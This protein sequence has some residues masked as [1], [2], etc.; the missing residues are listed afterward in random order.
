MRL[1]GTE[2]VAELARPLREELPAAVGKAIQEHMGP[3]ARQIER[4]GTEGVGEFVGDLSK[5]LSGEVGRALEQASA[6]LA[7]ASD[8]LAVLPIGWN[9]ARG[10]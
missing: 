1:L 3:L 9:P 8:R 5:Q 6:R 10:A 7:E 2:L 4:S